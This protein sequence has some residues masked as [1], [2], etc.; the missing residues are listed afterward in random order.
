MSPD[1]LEMTVDRTD[2]G[3]PLIIL[4][5]DIDL[6]V[7]PQI[8]EKLLDLVASSPGSIIVDLTDVGFIDAIGFGVLVYTRNRFTSRAVSSSLSQT[9]RGSYASSRSP[10][11]SKS[12]T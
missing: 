12:S 3:K 11:C 2:P 1:D 4:G 7:A 10:A 5:G 9:T 6:A 8:R